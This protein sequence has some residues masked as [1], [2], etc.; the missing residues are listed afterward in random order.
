[1]EES[2][3][4]CSNLARD[5]NTKKRKLLEVHKLLFKQEPKGQLHNALVDISVTLRIFLKLTKNIDICKIMTK[6]DNVIN[7]ETN[8]DICNLIN[9]LSIDDTE[10]EPI[11]YTGELI[12]GLTILPDNDVKEE[13]IMVESIYRS[14]ATTVVNNAKEKA[15]KSVL[16]KFA[17]ESPFICTKINICTAILKSGKRKGLVCSKPIS[18]NEGLCGY[19]KPKDF[20]KINT[21]KTHS[22]DKNLDAYTTIKSNTKSIAESYVNSLLHSLTRKT[23]KIVPSSGGKTI[24]KKNKKHIKTYKKRLNNKKIHFSRNFSINIY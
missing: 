6:I 14:L 18:F 24:P 2:K 23:H 13:K 7:V 9:P 5:G 10:I 21:E 12:T 11:N 22:L 4:I 15:V 20:S 3:I 16:S 19:H 17:Q 8:N 1:M